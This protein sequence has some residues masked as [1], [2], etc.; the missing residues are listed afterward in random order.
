MRNVLQFLFPYPDNSWTSS[1]LVLK[2]GFGWLLTCIGTAGVIAQ[3]TFTTSGTYTVPP[4]VTSLKVECWGGGGAGGGCPKDNNNTGGGGAGGAFNT[5]TVSVTPGQVI[6]Y[7]VG[8]GGVGVAGG[9]GGNGGASTFLSVT[10]AGGQGG[11]AGIGNSGNGIG[12]PTTIGDLNGGAGAN[13]L[14]FS[15][16]GGGGGGSGNTSGGSAAIGS[17]GGNGGAGSIPGGNG[18]N[19]PIVLQTNGSAA[20][21][22]AGAGSGAING[23]GS[24]SSILTGGNG[25]RGQITI[26]SCVLSLTSTTASGPICAGGTSTITLNGPAA[27]LPAGTYTVTYDL[28]SP[29]AAIGLTASMTVTTAGTGSF[30]TAA[31]ANAGNTMITITH[32]DNGSCSSPQSSGNFTTINIVADP[33]A[34]TGTKSPN[35]SAVCVGTSLSLSGVID[36]GGGAG[37][38][39]LEYRYD[40]GSG[41]TLWSTTP[42][43]FAAVSGTNT[44]EIRK[45]CSG[46]GCDISL[47]SSYSWSVVNDPAAPSATKSPNVASVCVGA[48]LTL[49]GVT[50]NGGGTGNC[51][52]EYS[53]N[54]GPWINSL[55]P[56]VAVAGVNSIAIRKNCDGSGC[57]ISPVMTYSWTG[58]ALP[59]AGTCNIVGDYCYTNNGSL[60]IQASGGLAPYNV[61]WTPA[62]GIP[63]PAVILTSGGSI[64]ITGLHAATSYTF[65]VIDSNNCQAP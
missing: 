35:L 14:A 10:A 12:G 38:C 47:T 11:T 48:M 17:S 18:A 28:A 31:L 36:N 63:Q 23:A 3:T 2:L 26:Y 4:G 50:D 64:S 46:A 39:N 62:H 49:S 21:T 8:A 27:N 42:A 30:S 34:P 44:I 52:I 33:S 5:A 51:T 16:G 20:T 53:H 6:N 43:N 22:L 61:T 9:N 60:E 32:L 59:T 41:F 54:G 65:V 29:N 25:F 56:I 37:S 1:R 13:G 15:Y 57:D 58:N 7:T 40:N 24:S 55:S 45:V 19:G